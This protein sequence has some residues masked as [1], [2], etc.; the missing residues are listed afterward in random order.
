M[1]QAYK[2]PENPR[3]PWLKGASPAGDTASACL[4]GLLGEFSAVWVTPEEGQL[5]A[6]RQISWFL[7]G[8]T[9]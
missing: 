7:L 6:K 2:T 4:T 3:T 1:L 9:L 5:E 8:P